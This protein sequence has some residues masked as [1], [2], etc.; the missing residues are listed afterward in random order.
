MI[1]LQSAS[2]YFQIHHP[3]HGPPSHQRCQEVLVLYARA[4][5][6]QAD[7]DRKHTLELSTGD[8]IYG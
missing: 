6:H 3:V 1:K 8:D 7:G 5:G 2:N 4:V